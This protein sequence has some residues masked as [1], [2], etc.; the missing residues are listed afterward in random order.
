MT[1][2][3]QMCVRV[4]RPGSGLCLSFDVCH[5]LMVL[6]CEEPGQVV[7]HPFLWLTYNQVLREWLTVTKHSDTLTAGHPII[8]GHWAV[9]MMS[10]WQGAVDGYAALPRARLIFKSKGKRLV[11]VTTVSV[12]D[13]L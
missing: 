9:V 7:R 3:T 5:S 1:L 6:D 12:C 11:S 4:R 10:S 2:C 8:H 13:W